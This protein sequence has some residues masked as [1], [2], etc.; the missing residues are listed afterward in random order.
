MQAFSTTEDTESTEGG[1]DEEG[2]KTVMCPG[3]PFS[4]RPG[5]I[6]MPLGAILSP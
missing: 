5:H 1:G 6:T 3:L 4:G 2:E